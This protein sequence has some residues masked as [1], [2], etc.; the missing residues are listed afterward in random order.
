MKYLSM[1]LISRPMVAANARGENAGNSQTLQHLSVGQGIH[2]VINGVAIAYAIR[3]AIPQLG[4]K[5]WRSI[6][7]TETASGY[8]YG[9]N[10]GTDA[11]PK[12][13]PTM[14]N[15]LIDM[16]QFSFDDTAL[17]GFMS[18][19]T[20]T[21]K[22]VKKGEDK[23]AVE[24]DTDESDATKPVAEAAVYKARGAMQLSPAVSTTPYE[25]E[26]AF[27]RGLRDTDGN[28]L[29]PFNFQRHYTRYTTVLCFDVATLK[30]R[31]TAIRHALKALRGLQIGGSH[32][33]NLSE[34]SPEVVA[35]RFHDAPGQ[36]G[37]FMS[38]PQTKDWTPEAKLDLAP[39]HAQMADLGI[40][41]LQIGGLSVCA[42]SVDDAL[43]Q[44]MSE[45]ESIWVTMDLMGGT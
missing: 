1:L 17:R 10:L 40:I 20:K 36:G 34:F 6:G 9:P 38:P 2:T 24:S 23:V 4:G 39:L 15:A 43:N 14:S 12:Y 21:P 41:D 11:D 25:D 31:P 3:A 44:I 7:T 30:R 13:S 37:L 26:P 27:A 35:W 28:N 33:S 16:D 45:V 42:K 29:L 32:T 5:V 19:Q 22:K 8:G 18:A